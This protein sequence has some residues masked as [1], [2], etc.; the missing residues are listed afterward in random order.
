MFGVNKVLWRL[1]TKAEWKKEF[2]YLCEYAE[3]YDHWSEPPVTDASNLLIE[4]NP[5]NR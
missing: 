1:L 5:V 3:V 2:I 4:A